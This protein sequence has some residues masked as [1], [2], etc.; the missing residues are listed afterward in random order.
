[1]KRI[2][3]KQGRKEEARVG[4]Q[5]KDGEKRKSLSK[6]ERVCPKATPHLF[7]QLTYPRTSTPPHLSQLQLRFPIFP[8]PRLHFLRLRP[9]IH[10]LPSPPLPRPLLLLCLTPSPPLS[11]LPVKHIPFL[12]PSHLRAP[13]WR[14]SALSLRLSL[15][16][17][18]VLLQCLHKKEI[19]E[20]KW[21]Y[22]SPWTH[23]LAIHPC[24]EKEAERG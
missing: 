13:Q 3:E 23:L 20:R 11:H 4:E 5:R 14:P 22:I 18:P 6:R 10:Q 7:L 12:S 17:L 8:F 19:G 16:G 21:R 2:R 15:D 9:C 1:M 24:E